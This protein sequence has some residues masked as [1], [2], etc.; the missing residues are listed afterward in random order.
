MEIV[1]NIEGKE[2]KVELTYNEMSKA[3]AELV[4]GDMKRLIM[5]N[6][7]YSEEVATE[8]AAHAYWAHY[9][10]DKGSK[11]ECVEMA[12]DEYEEGAITLDC[13]K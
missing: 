2:V 12:V 10:E 7:H 11:R 1:R 8:L 3:M 9:F 4:I 13:E 5:N 6:Y